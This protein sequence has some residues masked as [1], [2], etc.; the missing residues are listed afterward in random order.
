MRITAKQWRLVLLFLLAAVLFSLLGTAL[1]R[2]SEWQAPSSSYYEELPPADETES[3]LSQLS[4]DFTVEETFQSNLPIVVLTLE[5]NHGTEWS[6]AR[7]AFYEEGL[8]SRGKVFPIQVRTRTEGAEKLDYD[9]RLLGEN[10]QEV[11][12]SVLGMPEGSHF[13]LYAEAS[14]VTLLRSYIGLRTASS[15][16]AYTPRTAYC[17]VLIRDA[18]KLRY[19]GIY[20]LA[21]AVSV[22]SGRVAIQD[23]VVS[24]EKTGYMMRRGKSLDGGTPLTTWALEN[25][26]VQ[27]PLFVVHPENPNEE[28]L[29]FIKENFSSVERVICSASEDYAQVIDTDSFI[30]YFLVNEYFGN[31]R[32]GVEDV[33]F[34]MDYGGKLRMGPVSSFSGAMNAD[35]E[36]D[37]AELVMADSELFA[38]LMKRGDFLRELQGRYVELR[39]SALRANTVYA[40]INEASAYLSAAMVRNQA[41]WGGGDEWQQDL[42]RLKTYLSEHGKAISDRLKE[43]IEVDRKANEGQGGNTIF[44]VISLLLFFIPCI[45]VNRRS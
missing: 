18:G 4:A 37:S 32:A 26:S 14:D 43:R 6:V 1:Q 39:Q 10:G 2:Q 11:Q 42:Y 21:E 9:L 3:A 38:D 31:R 17:E 33:Y 35:K 16:L 44:F 34:I 8:Q 13:G 41:R 7:A 28:T 30:D 20:R 15:I 5:Q 25:G 22:S 27:Q 19:Q 12:A 23:N 29:S 24:S 40:T 45:L 36:A